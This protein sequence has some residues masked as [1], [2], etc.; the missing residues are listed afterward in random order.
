[1]FDLPY[2]AAWSFWVYVL[3]LL[4]LGAVGVGILILLVLGLLGAGSSS[5]SS[6]R[7]TYQYQSPQSASRPQSRPVSD[8]YK[9]VTADSWGRP[10]GTPRRNGLTTRYFD[11]RG[12]LTGSSFDGSPRSTTYYDAQGNITGRRNFLGNGKYEYR[13][14]NGTLLGTDTK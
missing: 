1:M 10:V 8:Y 12:Q 2:L 4:K 13:S 9:T 5:G 3:P 6:S 14:P 7:P 11:I